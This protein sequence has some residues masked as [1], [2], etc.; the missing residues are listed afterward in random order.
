MLAELRVPGFKLGQQFVA[1]AIA[2]ES[3]MAIGGVLAP[4]LVAGVQPRFDFGAGG[5]EEGTD[6]AGFE[7]WMDAGEALSPRSAQEL[8]ENGF[9]L[10]VEGVGSGDCIYFARRDQLAKPCITQAAGRAFNRI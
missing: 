3:E 9:G 7:F 6:D 5:V 2:R 10:V 1:N 4:G 8:G